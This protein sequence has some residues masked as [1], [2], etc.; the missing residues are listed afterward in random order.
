[1][2]AHHVDP[3]RRP[4]PT[5]TLPAFVSRV[6]LRLDSDP[7]PKEAWFLLDG[8]EDQAMIYYPKGGVV[9]RPA[10]GEPAVLLHHTSRGETRRETIGAFDTVT[11][12]VAALAVLAPHVPHEGDAASKAVVASSFVEHCARNRMLGFRSSR[13]VGREEVENIRAALLAEARAEY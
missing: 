12:A 2:T 1:M 7:A 9:S 5:V 6:E 10:C 11:D 8:T 4:T 13:E 3:G